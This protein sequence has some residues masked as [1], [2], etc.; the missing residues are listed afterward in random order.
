MKSLITLCIRCDALTINSH[1]T[2]AVNITKPQEIQEMENLP[3]Q[4]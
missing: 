1:H 2:V 4:Y 3:D